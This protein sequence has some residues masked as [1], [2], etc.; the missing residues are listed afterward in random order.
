MDKEMKRCNKWRDSLIKNSPV[1]QFMLQQLESAGCK[2]SLD[3][4]RCWPCDLTR[5]GGF[6]PDLGII[7]CQ[8]RLNSKTHMQDTMVHELIHA[9]DH[10]T[11]RIDWGIKEHHACAEI[12]AVT[13]SGECK[14]TR[15]L[16]RGNIG[17]AKHYQTCVQRR[18]LLG[19]SQLPQFADKKEAEDCML[20]VWKNCFNDTAPFDEI[21]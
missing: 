5:S 10:C 7:L 4:I 14:F 8:N 21:Y 9:F 17:F 6:A 12:R 11:T 18:V 16:R 13:L 1:I 3:N 19:L 15:E 2:Y 20:A